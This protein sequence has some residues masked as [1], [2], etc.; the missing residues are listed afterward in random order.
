MHI[1]RE[2]L[3]IAMTQGTSEMITFNIKCRQIFSDILGQIIDQGIEKNE[4]DEV[5]STMKSALLTFKLGLIVETHTAALDP[6]EEIRHFLDTL[7]TLSQHK[8]K[9]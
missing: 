4:I 5:F 3:A 1:Y 7:F 2:F 6:K 8:E 9:R